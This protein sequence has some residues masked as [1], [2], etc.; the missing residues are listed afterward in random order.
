MDKGGRTYVKVEMLHIISP[1]MYLKFVFS[2]EER[3]AFRTLWA[4]IKE[5]AV[6]YAINVYIETL[7][8]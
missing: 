4:M 6:L 5:L 2:I 8:G 1:W 3:L 7:H